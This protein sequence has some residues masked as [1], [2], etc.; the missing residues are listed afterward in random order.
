VRDR[1][2]GNTGNSTGQFRQHR[3]PKISFSNIQ[4][5]YDRKESL[6]W[7]SCGSAFGFVSDGS[8]EWRKRVD[9]MAMA[10]CVERDDTVGFRRT[11]GRTWAY[12]MR[13]TIMVS[14]P[15]DWR[16][17]LSY[18]VDVYDGTMPQKVASILP[19]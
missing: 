16:E 7:K 5:E 10:A 8:R 15:E 1:E 11:F 9:E 12:D 18:L 3:A 14:P 17:Y 19:P 2:R 4:I 6:L 13:A